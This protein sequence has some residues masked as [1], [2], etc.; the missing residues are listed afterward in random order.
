MWDVLVMEIRREVRQLGFEEL[1]TPEGVDAAVQRPGTTLVLIN[2]LCGCSGGIARPAAAI[3]LQE[4]PRPDHLVTVF[5]GQDREATARMRE[6]LVGQPPSSP[7]FA[8]LRDGKL[9]AM[10]HREDI[11]GHIPERVAAILRR[12]FEQYCAIVHQS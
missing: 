4:T 11:Q 7:S 1:R 8:L 6:Y 9:L 10:L 2:S 3:A 12:W 5:A